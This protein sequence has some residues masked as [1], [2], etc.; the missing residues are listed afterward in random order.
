MSDLCPVEANALSATLGGFGC[1]PIAINLRNPADLSNW[2]LP[3]LEALML[4]GAVAAVIFAVRRWREHH[5]P[6]PLALA[7]A[8]V[9]YV[10]V[11]EIP[12]YFPQRF[13]VENDIGTIF[14]HNVFTVEF[15][16]DRLPL[17]IVALYIALPLLAYEIVRS[18]GIFERRGAM[19][20]AVTVGAVHSS[21]YEVFDHLG[22][23]LRWW[24][25]NS[26]NSNNH[27]FFDA[28]PM[29][30]V[31]LFSLVAPIGLT[32]LLRRLVTQPSAAGRI[33]LPG[34]L[35]R[36]VLV[37]ALVPIAMTLG[38][39]PTKLVGDDTDLQGLL[40]SVELIA[41]W[42]IAIATL[43]AAVRTRAVEPSAYVAVFG[44]LYL[45]VMA[46]LWVSALPDYFDADNGITPDGTPVGNLPFAAVC[47]TAGLLAVV[48]AL[49]GSR[50]ATSERTAGGTQ[51]LGRVAAG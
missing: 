5:D 12:L 28:V 32:Y 50:S 48:A 45:A 1:G 36:A 24:A 51:G 23:Q 18:L 39:L 33:R 6:T 46:A 37:G 41:A 31:T 9:V 43:V 22:P 34:A 11:V 26:E 13:G 20:G 10:L 30:S 2:S 35:S 17:Y 16:A 44:P 38:A 3:V 29:T 19:L 42:A 7:V 21:F 4:I 14:V 8:G 40:F 27:P 49:R 47:F 15:I 25:W